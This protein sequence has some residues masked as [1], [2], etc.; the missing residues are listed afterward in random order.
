MKVYIGIAAVTIAVCIL[1][2]IYVKRKE[3]EEFFEAE[4]TKE[5]IKKLVIEAEAEIVGTK[6]GQE[7]LAL[8]VSRLYLII[9]LQIKAFITE[10]MIIDAINAIFTAI[11]VKMADG[12]TKAVDD[13]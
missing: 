13:E 9:P 10:E 11:A 7:R 3:V 2:I 6:K 12:T 5:F 4:S 1:F 8:C